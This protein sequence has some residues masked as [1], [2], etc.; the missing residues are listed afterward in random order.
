[1]RKIAL[2]LGVAATAIAVPTMAR[3]GEAYFGGEAGVVFPNDYDS[4]VNGADDASSD[5]E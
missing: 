5:R 4:R 3:D 2:C 1:M